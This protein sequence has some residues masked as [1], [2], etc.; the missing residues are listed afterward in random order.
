MRGEAAIDIENVPGDEAALAVVEQE[1]GG[2]GVAQA[3]AENNAAEATR[4]AENA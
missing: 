4:K 1:D 3:A 2:A